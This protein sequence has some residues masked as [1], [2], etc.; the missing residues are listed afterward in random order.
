[1]PAPLPGPH[2]PLGFPPLA[3]AGGQTMHQGSSTALGTEVGSQTARTTAAPP[4][5]LEPYPNRPR[6]P[7]IP[8]TS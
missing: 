2:V 3:M 1:M 7:L 4:A 5:A 8:T 6:V